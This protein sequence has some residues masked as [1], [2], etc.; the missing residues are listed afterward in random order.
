MRMSA[1]S[2]LELSSV[3]ET[4][5]TLQ[6][7]TGDCLVHWHSTYGLITIEVRQGRA[8]VNGDPVQPAGPGQA[9]DLA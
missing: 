4:G 7:V 6:P 3:R 1:P 9:K 8:Y 2:P 5:T